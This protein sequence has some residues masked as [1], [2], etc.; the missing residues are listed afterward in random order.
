MIARVCGRFRGFL[1]SRNGVSDE[2]VIFLKCVSSIIVFAT[3]RFVV[4]FIDS[5]DI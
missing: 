4:R 3:S 1:A 5:V 2:R